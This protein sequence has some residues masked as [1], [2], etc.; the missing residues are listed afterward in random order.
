M[1]DCGV[2]RTVP[3]GVIYNAAIMLFTSNKEIIQLLAKEVARLVSEYVG[4][5]GVVRCQLRMKYLMP[6]RETAD[7]YC[8]NS[9]NPSVLL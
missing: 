6:G 3:D 7:T 9:V 1:N 4:V 8:K 2:R 5:T